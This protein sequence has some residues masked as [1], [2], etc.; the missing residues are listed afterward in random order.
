M[1]IIGLRWKGLGV[2]LCYLSQRVY[3]LIGGWPITWYTPPHKVLCQQDVI[4]KWMNPN[5]WIWMVFISIKCWLVWL[6]GLV[7]LVALILH[8]LSYPWVV[9]LQTHELVILP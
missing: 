8:L 9:S 3:P 6:N 5:S 7:Q 4:R 1:I 2:R